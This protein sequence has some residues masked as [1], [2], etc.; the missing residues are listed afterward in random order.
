MLLRNFQSSF[1]SH[2]SALN[3]PTYREEGGD[4]R[5]FSHTIFVPKPTYSF[6]LNIGRAQ[7]AIQA[8]LH[9]EH[10]AKKHKK[11]VSVPIFTLFLPT[12]QLLVGL[13]H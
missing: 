10:T 7:W 13:K 8:S 6:S 2:F 3:T 5:V 9:R 4:E 1:M 11:D 12:A